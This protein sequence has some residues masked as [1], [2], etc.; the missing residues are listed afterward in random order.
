MIILYLVGRSLLRNNK[1]RKKMG[2]KRRRTQNQGKRTKKKKKQRVEDSTNEEM[3]EKEE[4]DAFQLLDKDPWERSGRCE[5]A[6]ENDGELEEWLDTILNPV[7]IPPPLPVY[8]SRGRLVR[9]KTFRPQDLNNLEVAMKHFPRLFSKIMGR[10]NM[11]KEETRRDAALMTSEWEFKKGRRWTKGEVDTPV[12]CTQGY[13]STLQPSKALVDLLRAVML[14]TSQVFVHSTR[15][16][17]FYVLLPHVI[18]P[19]LDN[20]LT[21]LQGVYKRFKN[22]KKAK[23]PNEPRLIRFDIVDSLSFDFL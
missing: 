6:G 2:G 3:E 13:L 7:P 9:P 21:R 18:P 14:T 16:L 4:D 5:L 22:I 15:L 23:F 8:T 12:R 11:R 20:L 17:H 1:N 19:N 10:G